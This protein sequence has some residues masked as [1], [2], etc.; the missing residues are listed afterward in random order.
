MSKTVGRTASAPREPEVHAKNVAYA[1]LVPMVAILAG[2]VVLFFLVKAPPMWCV[3]DM[4]RWD[5]VHSLV[6]KHTYAIGTDAEPEPWSTIDKVRKDDVYYSAKLPLLPTVL[7]K[8][9]W[10][11]KQLTGW[12]ITDAAHTGAITKLILFKWN[13]LL[14]VAFIWLY[15]RY[16]GRHVRDIWARPFWLLAAAF[17]TYVTSYSVTLN[18]HTLAATAGFFAIYLLVRIIHDHEHRWYYYSGVGLCA[19]WAAASE[20]TA[21][22]LLGLAFLLLLT[23]ANWRSTLIYALLPALAVI[24]AF[25]A[26]Q[27]LAMG[28]FKPAQM[29]K[30][31][32]L[33]LYPG[34]HW[35]NPVGIDAQHEK[36]WI[37]TLHMT[38]GH[39]GILSLN[40]I[41]LFVPVSFVLFLTSRAKRL[42]ELHWMSLIMTAGLWIF[43]T[44]YPDIDHNYG[45]GCKGLRWAFW[46]MPLWL[47]VA[48]LGAEIYAK[49]PWVRWAAIAAL[50]VSVFTTL[51][52][53]ASPWGSSWL[54]VLFQRWGIVGY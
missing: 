31:S 47:M 5:T 42:A 50:A 4:S 29:Q 15:G 33:Y 28:E 10:I 35:S 18:N 53:L 14:L 16:V 7:A 39:H 43:Y 9:Y 26:T 25:F 44:F 19:A 30:H 1:A 40:P 22:M 13:V 6:D 11:I 45:G 3:N 27:Y 8:D 49:K 36:W 52:G 17:G 34:S 46:M 23:R 48:P 21:M 37:Y 38:V 2:V 24:A 20:M 12:S 51:D 32:S 54:H 41:F